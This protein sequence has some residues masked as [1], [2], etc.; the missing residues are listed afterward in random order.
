M[1]IYKNNVSG[2]NLV[3]PLSFK[4]LFNLIKLLE[5]LL[6]IIVTCRT[7]KRVSF[8]FNMLKATLCTQTLNSDF[9]I[10]VVNRQPNKSC[11]D[12]NFKQ[13]IVSLFGVSQN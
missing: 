3:Q 4:L 13:W 10:A 2:V 5:Q 6:P 11:K 12:P 7:G 9:N 1:Q 8:H